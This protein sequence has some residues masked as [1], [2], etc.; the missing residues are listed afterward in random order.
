VFQF[1]STASAT[2]ITSFNATAIANIR[3]GT[4]YIT[5]ATAQ[6]F[7]QNSSQTTNSPSTGFTSQTLQLGDVIRFEAFGAT[8]TNF[9]YTFIKELDSV[10]TILASGTSQTTFDYTI[11]SADIAA[12]VTRFLCVVQDTD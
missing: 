2:T 3:L 1:R 10:Q 7:S 9:D 12:T 6:V 11:Q 5:Q 4:Q 8:A